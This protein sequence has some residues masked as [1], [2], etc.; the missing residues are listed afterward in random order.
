GFVLVLAIAGAVWIVRSIRP[1]VAGLGQRL[2]P[3]VWGA[4][5]F[6][7][8]YLPFTFQRKLVMGLHL[9]LAFL[10]AVG[11]VALARWVTGRAADADRQRSTLDARRS[12]RTAGTVGVPVERRASSV[13]RR[14]SFAPIAVVAGLLLL[15]M[16]TDWRCI[17]RD[18]ATALTHSDDLN[19]LP[20]FV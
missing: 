18:M 17:Q 15:T 2:M 7:L 9:P 20:T 1:A 19:Q 6:V 16:P 3:V 14:A 5:G 8:P 11:A 10:A 13:E 12:A 4:V